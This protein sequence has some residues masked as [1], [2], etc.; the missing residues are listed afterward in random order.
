MYETSKPIATILEIRLRHT[1]YQRRAR[2]SLAG[3][4]EACT[5]SYSLT[6]AEPNGETGCKCCQ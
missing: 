2:G 3:A 1:A 6:G 4:L 5:M